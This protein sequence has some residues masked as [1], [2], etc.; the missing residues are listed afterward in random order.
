[1]NAGASF[2]NVD[3]EI[4]SSSKLD[5]L[6]M[7][8]GERVYVLYSGPKSNIGNPKR[9]LLVLETARAYKEPNANIRAF[10]SFVESLS[11]ASHKLWKRARTMFDV[12]CEMEPDQQA[13]HLSFDTKTLERV[14]R[15]GATLTVTCYSAE[16]SLQR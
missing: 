4:E 6:A 15:L 12:G 1:M 3:L 8:L 5:V 9:Y 14:V 11:P 16:R 10:C 7:E 2:L 13:L